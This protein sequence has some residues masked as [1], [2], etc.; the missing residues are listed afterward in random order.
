VRRSRAGVPRA[1]AAAHRCSG[2][3]RALDA[4]GIA[5][6]EPLGDA[7]SEGIRQHGEPVDVH[8]REEIIER[9]WIIVG[10]RRL[11]RQRVG[12][13]VARRVPSDDPEDGVSR[14]LRLSFG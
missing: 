5:R 6:G 12:Q 10:R 14:R 7:R 13:Q 11:R 9:R 1:I 2:E 8:G 4:V 3:H